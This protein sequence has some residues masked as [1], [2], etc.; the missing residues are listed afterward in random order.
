MRFL[1]SELNSQT[2]A[3]R[4]GRAILKDVMF[5]REREQE[6][7]LVLE[8]NGMFRRP[9]LVI[10]RIRAAAVAVCKSCGKR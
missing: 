10:S 5:G 4:T 9:E 8:K 6:T 2:K 3:F 1:S 7:L